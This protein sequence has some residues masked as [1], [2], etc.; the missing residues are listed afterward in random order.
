M[1]LP[2]KWVLILLLACLSL[3]RTVG[4][5]SRKVKQAKKKAE[6]KREEQLNQAVNAKNYRIE[7]HF[8]MQSKEVQ[9]RM[10]ASSKKTQKHYSR[11]KWMY[12]LQAIF[13]KPKKNYGR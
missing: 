6:K 5:E 11:K 3:E 9:E 8:K 7:H 13:S 12:K 1:N 10:K 2:G 4:Q